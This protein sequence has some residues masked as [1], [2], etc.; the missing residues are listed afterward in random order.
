MKILNT[1][2]IEDDR[3][4]QY[5]LSTLLAQ[6]FPQISLLAQCY[7][8]A[9]GVAAIKQMKPDLI[10]LDIDLGDKSAFQLLESL[11]DLNFEIIFVSGYANFAA[12]AFRWSAVDY[13]VKPVTISLLGEALEK[14]E[15]RLLMPNT[16]EQ[17]QLLLENMNSLQRAKPLVKIALPTLNEIEFVNV[18]DIVRVE[19]D[20]NYSTFF[21]SDKRKITVS[22]TL[23]EYE[24]MLEGITFMRIQ[25][26]HLVNLIY[27]KKYLKG[28]G[29][30]VLTSDGAQVPVSPLKRDALFSQLSMGAEV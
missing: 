29:G 22:R 1:I 4:S 12:Q 15:R 19:G 9:E 3:D 6:Y 23:G 27:V 24:K 14:A 13:L 11:E 21:L 28:D 25:K 26:S 30:W 16:I 2:I 17:I 8:A 20:K 18:N 5:V 7:N 10:F